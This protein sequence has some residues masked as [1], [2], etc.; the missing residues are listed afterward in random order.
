MGFETP[1]GFSLDWSHKDVLRAQSHSAGNK[2]KLS[3]LVF[4][5]EARRLPKQVLLLGQGT[6]VGHEGTNSSLRSGVSS[7]QGAP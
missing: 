7:E 1:F 3:C 2:H 5:G 6:H 4:G